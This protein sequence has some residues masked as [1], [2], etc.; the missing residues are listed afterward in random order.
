MVS[1]MFFP[2]NPVAICLLSF[3]YRD[4]DH[5][6]KLQAYYVFDTLKTTIKNICIRI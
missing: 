5:V 1:L 2:T 3:H 4:T 6:H